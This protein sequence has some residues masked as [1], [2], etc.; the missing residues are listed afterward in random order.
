MRGRLPL[1]ALTLLALCGSAAAD[2]LTYS[3]DRFGTHLTF[4]AELFDTRLTPP[5][6]GDGMSWTSGEGASLS[7][8]GAYNA[9]EQ[10]PADLLADISATRA[11]DGQ[12]TYAR[13]RD[14]WVV[15]TGTSGDD[16]FYERH[17]FGA[18]DA[19]HSM[20]LAYPR[21]LADKY[22]PL[23]GPIANSLGGP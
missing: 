7:V 10:S 1:A 5:D 16:V 13:T 17:V 3:N 2:S 19:I 8:Y 4:P 23:V 21:K 15:V 14:N 18:R 20:V 9:L 12:V 22:N 6:N 11:A